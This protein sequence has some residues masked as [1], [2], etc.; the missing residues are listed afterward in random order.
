MALSSYSDSVTLM[1][2]ES[3][4]SA[5]STAVTPPPQ[6]APQ[7]EA[8]PVAPQKIEIIPLQPMMIIKRS[9]KPEGTEQRDG[10]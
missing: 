5:G 1:A 3:S 4:D 2:G 6:Q 7:E 9:G 8:P 10:S